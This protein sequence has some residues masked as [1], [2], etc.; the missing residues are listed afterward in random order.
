M[1]RERQRERERERDRERE[2]VCERERER[3]REVQSARLGQT[4]T[5]SDHTEENKEEYMLYCNGGTGAHGK[6]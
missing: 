1:K 2:R 6:Q 5:C 4:G 3:E